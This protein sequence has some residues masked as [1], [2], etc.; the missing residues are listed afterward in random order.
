MTVI[1]LENGMTR[2]ACVDVDAIRQAVAF[3]EIELMVVLL[4]DT[5]DYHCRDSYEPV[6]ILRRSLAQ[7][8]TI[9]HHLIRHVFYLGRAF[10]EEMLVVYDLKN[11]HHRSPHSM[12]ASLSTSTVFR[13]M[14]GQLTLSHIKMISIYTVLRENWCSYVIHGHIFVHI[15][16]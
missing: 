3:A 12:S 10:A 16:I 6:S 15:L 13:T 14:S 5:F 8:S 1:I 7:L 4:R 9:H 2:G 11:S